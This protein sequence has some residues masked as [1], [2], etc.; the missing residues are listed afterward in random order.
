MQVD[1]PYDLRRRSLSVA[2]NFEEVIVGDET[3][4][5]LRELVLLDPECERLGQQDSTVGVQT[6]S[7]SW[8]GS[9][10]PKP[11]TNPTGAASTDS[12]LRLVN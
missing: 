11:T 7:M 12:T 6:T 8:L 4:A 9:W 10:P 3:A 1:T 5:A 2:G